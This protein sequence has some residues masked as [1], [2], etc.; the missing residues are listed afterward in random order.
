MLLVTLQKG[1][2]HPGNFLLFRCTF[3]RLM[4]GENLYLN[5]P[6]CFGYLYSPAFAFLFAPFAL[7]P[8]LVGLFCWNAVNAAVP[9][10]AISRLLDPRRARLVLVFIYLDVVRSMQNSQSN[11]L[12]AGL[13]LL[14]FL[15][16]EHEVIVGAAFATGL[17]TLIK[18]FPA[19]GG[20]FALVAPQP[21]GAVLKRIALFVGAGTL[22]ALTPL[23]VSTPSTVAAQYHA[24]L[25][26][27]TTTS[28]L[29]GESV[30]GML[31]TWFAYDGPN[32]PVQLAGLVILMAPVIALRDAARAAEFRRLVL[33]SVLV[34]VVI[35]N[36]QAESP[37][38]V[39]ATT[40]I[41][42]WAVSLGERWRVALA[43]LTLVLVSLVAT[44]LVPWHYR[45]DVLRAYS[46]QALPC[47]ICW[48][49]I[50]MD[51]WR[52]GLRDRRTEPAAGLLA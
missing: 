18:I 44:S 27:T 25:T 36:H 11:A 17:G 30:L 8:P 39:I 22:L 23:I 1:L 51:I 12:V 10:L 29:R 50:Q 41:G 43:I 33:C 13:L 5:T 47:L 38:Y 31:G 3:D 46:V 21:L 9:A 24:W 32:W 6:G 4:H 35:F 2:T 37:S 48:L 26:T 42:I 19:A 16:C 40:G 15:A 14:T 52:M 20:V 49:G 28:V 34:F 7:L 45:H